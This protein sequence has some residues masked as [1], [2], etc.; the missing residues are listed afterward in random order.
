MGIDI[1]LMPL[2]AVLVSLAAAILIVL[3]SRSPNIRELWTILAGAVKFGAVLLMLPYV[4]AGAS[5]EVTLL[6]ISPGV[7]LALK[8]DML[9]TAFALSASALWIATSFY[10]I[11]YT[12]SEGMK[13]QTRYYASFCVC[14]SSAMGMSFAANLLTFLIFYEVLTIATYPLVIHKESPEAIAA[15][16]KY[17]FYL[18][19]GGMVLTVAVALTYVYAGSLDFKA[20]GFL[21]SSLGQESLM[22]LA[23]LYIIGC[24]FKAGLMPLHGWLP[25]AMIAPS[26]VSGLLHAVAVVKAGV[27]GILRTVG[28]VFGPTLF[29]N[30]GAANIVA[31][32]AAITI[33][34][35]SLLAFGQD[36]IKRRLAYSTVCHLSYIVLGVTLLSPSGWTGSVLELVFHAAGKITLFLCAGAIMVK[37]GI[38]KVSELDGVGRQMPITM[39]AFAIGTLGL[40]GLPPIAGFISKWFLGTGMMEVHEPVLL[41]IF[42]LSDLLTVG[43]L[44]PILLRSF[45]VPSRRFTKFGEASPFMVVPLVIT[46]LL[47]LIWGLAPNAIFHFYTL[48]SRIAM[49]LLGGS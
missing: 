22:L 10:S 18:L 41:A 12:R 24:G 49:S 17:L 30:I 16:R 38:E 43:Y 7:S 45:F 39:G 33:L 13:K 6:Q 14:M 42:L 47:S 3:S 9:G 34:F 5:P 4:L 35:S 2:V 31:I 26:P 44:F 15:G 48:A 11:G 32:I 21:S 36:N 23:M 8:A 19:T 25:T 37:T 29:Y 1:N 20:G 28:F 40:S 27:F 46:A